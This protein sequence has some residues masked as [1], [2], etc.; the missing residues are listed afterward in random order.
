MNG[1]L[2]KAS[3][4]FAIA[5][6][7]GLG[8][9]AGSAWAADLGG[10]CCAD[11][12]ERIAELEATTARKGNRKMSLTI[13]G[14][15][16]R[17]VLWWD[18]THLSRAYFGLD[19]SN[20][21]SRLGFLGS[22][23][24]NP[25]VTMGFEFLMDIGT[26]QGGTTFAVNQLD[27]DGK[28]SVAQPLGNNVSFNTANSTSDQMFWIRRAA[29]WIEHKDVGRLTVGRFESAGVV[30]T[31][32][33]GGILVV[34]SASVSLVNGLFFVRG[35]QGQYYSLTWGTGGLGDP[36]ANQGRTELV[37]YTSPTWQ[38]FVFDSSI[39]ERGDYWGSMLRYANEFNGVRIAAGIGYEKVRDSITGVT[40]DPAAAVFVGP[41]PDIDAWGGA[42]S[43]MHVPTGLF[44]QG[45]YMAA[46]YSTNAANA[47]Y[48]GAQ[49]GRRDFG[50]WLIQAGIAKNW[51]G[52][53]NTAVYGEYARLENA[54]ANDFPGRNFAGSSTFS[55]PFTGTLS[56]N[57]VTVNGVTDT[58]LTVWGFG[59]TQN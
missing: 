27:E 25:S 46:E 7:L 1:A 45:H 10:N 47:G 24:V 58:E 29:T 17:S 38:G 8:L 51:F 43:V 52:P 37:R 34:A 59:M 23:E 32:D 39:G 44:A 11:L 14:Q 54:A 19:N 20:S 21:S 40:L 28:R 53:G 4:R 16:N 26:G 6:A 48:W 18:D 50:F 41:Q 42:L 22:A 55:T 2:M 5:A 13:T 3:S 12:E 36:A 33:L 49:N 57:F 56:Q 30:A 31:I 15:V 9:G 35:P